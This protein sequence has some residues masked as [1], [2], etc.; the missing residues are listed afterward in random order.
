MNI[1][2]ELSAYETAKDDGH[3]TKKSS[4][5][6]DV[7]IPLEQNKV[8]AVP[9]KWNSVWISVN[10]P[11]NIKSGKYNIEVEFSENEITQ[12]VLLELEIID[13]NLEK[14]DF[15]LLQ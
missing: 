6:Y 13:I 11:Q 15:I 2:S 7:I 14:Q 12:K 1:P 4:L 8:Y 5:F 3:Y 9:N 10:I